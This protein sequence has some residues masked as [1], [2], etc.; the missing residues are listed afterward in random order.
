[1]QHMEVSGL[2]VESQRQ[3]P[4]YTTAMA[5]WDLSHICGLCHSLQQSRILHLLSKAR[6]GT[7]IL[8]DATSG[9]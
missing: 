5:I 2:G 7:C 9:S 4:A 6:D 8:M 1:M 3:L